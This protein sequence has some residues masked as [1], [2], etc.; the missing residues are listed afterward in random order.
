[1][2]NI[3]KLF[4]ITIILGNFVSCDETVDPLI[5][6]GVETENRTFIS[7]ERS[8]Y[9][10]PVPIN[11]TGSIQII[12]NASTMSPSERTFSLQLDTEKTTAESATFSLPSTVTI[13]ANEYQ[14][15]ITIMGMDNDLV[16]PTPERIV[17]N[18]T[19]L[20]DTQDTDFTEVTV[21]IFEVCPLAAPFTGTYFLEQITAINP[22]DGVNVFEDQILE[23]VSEGDNTR[24]FSAVYL[25]GLG[26]GQPPSIV[27]FNLVCNDVIVNPGIGTGLLCVQGSPVITLGP[28]TTPATYDPEDDSV[29]EINMTEYVTDGGCGAAPYQVTFRLTK[30]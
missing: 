28:G 5:Y 19:G 13:P 10:L 6:N 29:F 18:L 27:V 24:S 14:G 4:L 11:D 17:F 8:V 9:N 22:D 25:E 12:L 2:K 23:V 7:F 21:N 1:M 3:F 20:S 30:Q 16:E 15:T 26:I